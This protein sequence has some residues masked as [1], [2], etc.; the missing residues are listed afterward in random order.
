MTILSEREFPGDEASR[1]SKGFTI[2]W[3]EFSPQLKRG[4][5][6]NRV[7]FLAK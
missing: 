2:E 6:I 3:L 5:E 1:R 4:I 7:F